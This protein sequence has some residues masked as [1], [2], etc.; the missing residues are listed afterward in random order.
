MLRAGTGTVMEGDPVRPPP[1]LP[2][3]EEFSWHPDNWDP[4]LSFYEIIIQRTWLKPSE[5]QHPGTRGPQ[6][7]SEG[8]GLWKR[9][10]GV[11]NTRLGLLQRLP[12]RHWWGDKL[13]L[14]RWSFWTC[15][16]TSLMCTPSGS[17]GLTL[18]NDL[19]SG[20][21]GTSC[22]KWCWFQSRA[23]HQYT[24]Q[25][26]DNLA[27]P[28]PNTSSLSWP[29]MQ[30]LR[31]TMFHSREASFTWCLLGFFH[32]REFLCGLR[33]ILFT[34]FPPKQEGRGKQPHAHWVTVLD[35]PFLP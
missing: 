19:L 14:L 6:H 12:E 30:G 7:V 10:G 16:Q 5:P 21:L 28:Q 35:G 32:V 18:E 2:S 8:A 34:D 22:Q 13:K 4:S 29:G 1:S 3:W 31:A 33:C 26:P 15:W 24:S 9:K 20:F 11:S 23:I 17:V 27:L 25:R